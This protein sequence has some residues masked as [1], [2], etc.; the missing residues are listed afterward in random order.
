MFASL[1]LAIGL[2]MDATAVAA[3]QGLAGR[4]TGR[5]LRLALLFGGFQA[6]MA[7]LGWLGG[8]TL[9]D[10]FARWDHWVAFVLLVGLGAKMLWEARGGDDADDL[11]DKPRPHAPWR[12]DLT[13]AVATSIDALAAGVT[14][15]LVAPPVLA[16]V[17]IGVVTAATSLVAYAFAM[18][19]GSRTGARLNALGGIVL[20]GM[21]TKIL[22]EHLRAETPAPPAAV[23]A[24]P[25]VADVVTP[26]PAPVGRP[27]DAATLTALA[28]LRPPAVDV[29]VRAQTADVVDV[30]WRWPAEPT[31]LAELELSR[32]LGCVPL[33]V[34]AWQ[35][36]ADA[37][38][39]MAL[40]PSLRSDASVALT[41]TSTQVASWP[42][43]VIEHDA[44]RLV[45]EQ[46]IASHGTIAVTHDGLRQL[47]VIVGDEAVAR[48]D[49]SAAGSS[50][51]PA[52]A[53]RALLEAALAAAIAT[54]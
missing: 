25:P 20:I 18:R 35:A 17:A 45:G 51:R 38:R 19:L 43:I 32:C 48:R 42:A 46:P 16:L 40:P 4:E 30:V 21:G 12:L 23:D 6:G 7:A 26:D 34:D 13:L 33:T 28:A 27:L 10:T 44:D 52:T 3:V 31:L 1:A 47:R 24:A 54:L 22:I 2:A 41:I 49:G 37:L 29:T 53:R 14:L 5:G 9:G 15:P 11:G 50:A 36:T 39:T 8:R